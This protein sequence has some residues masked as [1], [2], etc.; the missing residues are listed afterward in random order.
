MLRGKTWWG[1]RES[2]DVRRN[3]FNVVVVLL[4]Y[5][6]IIFNLLLILVKIIHIV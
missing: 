5:L 2:E 1:E 3:G 4:L 6:F